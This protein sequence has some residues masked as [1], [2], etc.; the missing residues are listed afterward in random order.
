MALFGFFFFVFGWLCV[1]HNYFCTNIML[2]VFGYRIYECQLADMQEV[3]T[4]QKI[5]SKRD[6]RLCQGILYSKSL[7]ND[8]GYDCYQP[9]D[10][11]DG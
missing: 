9:G 2:D 4:K 7:N 3:E 6:L 1:Q 5:I 11:E 10:M 8:Y